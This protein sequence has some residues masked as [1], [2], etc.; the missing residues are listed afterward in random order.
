MH[1][2]YTDASIKG[3]VLGVGYVIY[4]ES[5]TGSELVEVAGRA[6]NTDSL[7]HEYD[8]M[9]G[10]YQAMISGVRALLDHDPRAV[11]VFNDNEHVVERAKRGERIA[12]DGYFHH[13]LHSFLGRF[14]W[15]SITHCYRDNN[16]VAHDQA[17]VAREAA[18]RVDV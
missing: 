12:E 6:C 1:V 10:E 15:W 11:L 7:P 13:A 16:E 4:D 5:G 17:R 9:E 2:V 18:E 8:S 3:D 14:D